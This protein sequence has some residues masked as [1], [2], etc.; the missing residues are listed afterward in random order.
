MSVVRLYGARTFE[1][2]SEQQCGEHQSK[3]SRSRRIFD[4]SRADAVSRYQVQSEP[5]EVGVT[6]EATV[7]VDAA[8]GDDDLD[9]DDDLSNLNN[10]FLKTAIENRALV[11]R[12]R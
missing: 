7:A 10:P 12:S 8:R 5:G 9:A 3:R 11:Y 4:G 1:L 6:L 2:L